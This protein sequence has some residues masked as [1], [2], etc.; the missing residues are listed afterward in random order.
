M[1]ERFAVNDAGAF[2]A[3]FSDSNFNQPIHLGPSLRANGSRECA[4]DDRLREAIH[5]S[6]RRPRERGDPYAVPSMFRVVSMALL[7]RRA[8]ATTAGGY[9]SPRSRGRRADIF[10]TAAPISDTAS[11]SRGAMRPS[12]ART[13]SLEKQRAQGSRGP[14]APAASRAMCRKHTSVVPTAA[15]G[16][17]AFPAQWF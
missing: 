3:Y 15:P 9:G 16:H 2:R 5:A 7:D 8:P 12:G 1:R 6:Q 14:A 10:Q 17:P 13:L 4:P 11:P